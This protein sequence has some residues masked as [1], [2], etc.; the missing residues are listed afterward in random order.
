[1]V[2]DESTVEFI[3]NIATTYYR[4]GFTDFLN[5]VEESSSYMRAESYLSGYRDAKKLYGNI[6]TS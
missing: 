2:E 6:K 3:I 4:E 5:G 1:M